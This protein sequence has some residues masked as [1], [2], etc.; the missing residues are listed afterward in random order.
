LFLIYKIEILVLGQNYRGQN[1]IDK[2]VH[3][4][5][6]IGQN[7]ADKMV[8]TKWYGSYNGTRIISAIKQSIP[9]PLAI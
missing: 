2:M 7:Y 6:G 4:Q 3:G 8:G 1:G 9:L 5:N